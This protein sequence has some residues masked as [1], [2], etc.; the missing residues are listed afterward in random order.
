MGGK[1]FRKK[2]LILT[3][4]VLLIAVM[5]FTLSACGNEGQSLEGKNIVTFELTGGTLELKPSS[6]DTKI[7][8]AYHPG[9][10]ILDPAQI[11]GYKL[12]RQEYNFTGWYTSTE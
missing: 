1:M 9:T 11:P 7:N 10:Y 6:V 8:F 3:F 4:S 12:F 5:A 2:S